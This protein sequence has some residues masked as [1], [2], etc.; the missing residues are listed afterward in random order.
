[1]KQTLRALALS[2]V[3]LLSGCALLPSGEGAETSVAMVIDLP[4]EPQTEVA[5][6]PE[7]EPETKGE[8]LPPET[9]EFGFAPE[10]DRTPMY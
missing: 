5:P 2:I 7:T 4:T 10:T 3:L 8:T 1:M 9:N 6:L